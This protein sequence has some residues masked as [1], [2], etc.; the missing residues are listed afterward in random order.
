MGSGNLIADFE[1]ELGLPDNWMLDQLRQDDWSFV[2]KIHA[3]LESAVTYALETAVEQLAMRE[4]VGRLSLSGRAS[5]LALA[6]L[7]DLLTR[8]QISFIRM[9]S[10]I[11]NACVHDV[12]NVSFSFAKFPKA[13]AD[14]FIDIALKIM[15]PPRGSEGELVNIRDINLPLK[16]LI[17]TATIPT[18]LHL[19]GKATQA[20]AI[21]NARKRIFE[22]AKGA[23]TID[24]I[25][26]W[27]AM[28]GNIDDWGKAG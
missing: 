21:V 1:R 6:E 9:L 14:R 18:I 13:D 16:V 20:Q 19:Y 25:P 7:L 8:D 12:R 2:V 23:L 28:P 27:D 15:P 4:F 11:R 26:N 10:Q 22:Q 17:I 5:K 24:D 3:L